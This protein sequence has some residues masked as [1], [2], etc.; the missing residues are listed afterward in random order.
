[1]SRILNII[2]TK[3]F[4]ATTL[5]GTA[6]NFGSALNNPAIK[7]VLQNTSDVDADVTVNADSDDV[8]I[9]AGGSLTL[10][11]ATYQVNNLSA[12]YYIPEGFQMQIT[13]VTGAGASGSIIAHVVTREL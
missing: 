11:E 8:R 13:Q 10:D 7:I 5:S 12:S 6:Q 1:M 3:V 2:E 4:D 9:V